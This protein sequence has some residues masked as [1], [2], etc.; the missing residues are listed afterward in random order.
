MTT[1]TDYATEY[2]GLKPDED[3]RSITKLVDIERTNGYSGMTD[4]EIANLIAYK[5]HVARLDAIASIDRAHNE[6]MQVVLEENAK[7]EKELSDKIFELT[8]QKEVELISVT[9]NEV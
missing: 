3:T 4:K 6:K 1:G 7:K 5:E 8:T 2:I 9:G